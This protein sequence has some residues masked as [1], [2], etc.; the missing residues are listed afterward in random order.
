MPISEKPTKLEFT[1][2]D[3]DHKIQIIYENNKIIIIN[4]P[5]ETGKDSLL[6]NLPVDFFVEVVDFLK[7]KGIVVSSQK[8]RSQTVSF[9]APLPSSELSAPVIEDGEKGSSV[10]QDIDT[11]ASDAT[12]PLVALSFGNKKVSEEGP[13][14]DATKIENKEIKIDRP[15]IKT[16]EERER[17]KKDGKGIK[18][19]E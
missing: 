3:K 15:L 9:T 17:L 7:S 19:K 2:E 12:E 4:P 16:P 13:K 8:P 6:I 18:R 5:K 11:T 1:W 10:P 14:I